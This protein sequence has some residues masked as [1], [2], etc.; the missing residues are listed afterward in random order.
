MLAMLWSVVNFS[1]LGVIIRLAI[2]SVIDLGLPFVIAALSF[3]ISGRA[4]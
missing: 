3:V 2:A 4:I 1:G